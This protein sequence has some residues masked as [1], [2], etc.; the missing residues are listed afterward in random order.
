MPRRLIKSFSHAFSGVF[1]VFSSQRNMRIHFI[2]ALAVLGIAF[3]LKVK[4][5]EMLVLFLI[6]FFVLLIE[7]FNTIIEELA[8]LLMPGHS[9]KVA[10]IKDMAAG[11]VL[12]AS[13]CAII[14][15]CFIFIPYL[16]MVFTGG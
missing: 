16:I 9:R 14:L 2:I 11:A 10:V 4:I 13:I 15:G 8:D 5:I 3:F 1:F 7:L 12:L 6:V